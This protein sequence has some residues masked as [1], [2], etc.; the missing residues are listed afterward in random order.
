MESIEIYLLKNLQQNLLKNIILRGVKNIPKI[1]IRKVANSLHYEN[2]QYK[3]AMIKKIENINEELVGYSS[4]NYK[5]RPNSILIAEKN[6]TE[7]TDYK[8]KM[9]R[10]FILPKLIINF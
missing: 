7:A 8:D 9:S 6:N 10:P 4:D 1:I 3:I 5:N 2:G